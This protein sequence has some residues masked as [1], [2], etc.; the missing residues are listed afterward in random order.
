MHATN[1]WRAE[2]DAV[3]VACIALHERQC[4]FWQDISLERVH[5]PDTGRRVRLDKTA[6]AR[7]DA[8]KTGASTIAFY[9]GISIF[10]M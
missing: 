3:F 2:D 7:S 9:I 4:F 1:A 5:G 8:L 10:P 6:S